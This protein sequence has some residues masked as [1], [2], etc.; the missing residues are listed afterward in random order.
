MTLAVV[1]I[2]GDV[3]TNQDIRDTLR[4]L[5]LTRQNHLV[6]VPD[7]AVTKGML[8]KVKDYV[9]WGEPDLETLTKVIQNR[10]RLEGD[11][12]LTDEYIKANSGFATAR[13]FAAAVLGQKAKYSDLND[14]TP[15]IR[16]HPPRGG[17]ENTK[18]SY[19]AG[20]S[21]GRRG[22]AINPLLMRMLGPGAGYW[23]PKRPPGKKGLA[24][25][26]TKHA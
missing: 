2:R 8:Q 24:K 20:G 19:S 16:L 26:G 4:M 12:L 14:I 10:G 9:T 6:F 21:L 25:G 5:R 15:V 7:N 18:T 11:K 1:R 13:D 23:P 22:K 3:A 17:F